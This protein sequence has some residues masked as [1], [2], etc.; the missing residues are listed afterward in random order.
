VETGAHPSTIGNLTTS[1]IAIRADHD[2]QHR[3]S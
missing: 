3:R 1:K 2:L